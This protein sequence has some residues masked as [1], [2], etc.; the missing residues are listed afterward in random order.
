MKLNHGLI[1]IAMVIISLLAVG[2]ASASENVSDVIGTTD[3]EEVISVDD[4]SGDTVAIDDM[5][6][7]VMV[8]DENTENTEILS[9]DNGTEPISPVV[10][11]N[12]GSND[13]S[14]KNLYDWKILYGKNGTDNFVTFDLSGFIGKNNTGNSF[15]TFDLNTFG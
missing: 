11:E 8:V 4:N 15:L 9:D 3:F 14:S 5:S 2:V 13:A 1:V 10:K 6:D 12:E 7:D